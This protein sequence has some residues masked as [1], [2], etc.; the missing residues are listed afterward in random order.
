[1]LVLVISVTVEY[2][3]P[4]IEAGLKL[5]VAPLGS[6]VALNATVPVNP[7][8]GFTKTFGYPTAPADVTIADGAVLKK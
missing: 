4:V 7:F 1:V 3:E 8:T 2:P 5:T 6:P